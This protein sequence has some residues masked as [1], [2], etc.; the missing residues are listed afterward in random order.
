MF[1]FNLSALAYFAGISKI[2]SQYCYGR[3]EHGVGAMRT[4]TTRIPWIEFQP[5]V[6][7][8]FAWTNF[9]DPPIRPC[10][11]PQ[12]M[13]MTTIVMIV[14]W[15]FALIWITLSCKWGYAKPIND[16]LSYRPML[17]LSRLTYCA[18]L[19]HPVTQIVMSFQL[20]GPVHIQHAL[21]LTI[22]MGNAIIS[23]ICALVLSVM[24]EAPVVRMLKILFG[25]WDATPSAMIWIWNLLKSSKLYSL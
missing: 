6:F 12:S 20:K 14:A 2:S 16:L 13:M 5:N 18:Y 25:R 22:F 24:F 11:R 3:L 23:Y 15:G 21:V 8:L 19:I 1:D 7:Y 9:V 10:V 4:H 17:P